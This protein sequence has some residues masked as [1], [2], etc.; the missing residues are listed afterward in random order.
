MA[1][2][3]RPWTTRNLAKWL[4]GVRVGRRQD[5][6]GCDIAHRTGFGRWGIGRLESIDRWGGRIENLMGGSIRTRS[7]DTKSAGGAQSRRWMNGTGRQM[8]KRGRVD[9]RHPDACLVDFEQLR[10]ERVE[11][12]VSFGKVIEGQLLPVPGRC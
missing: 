5:A 12:D 9:G 6:R 11:V 3:G 7:I 10:H 8:G 1:V 2:D 4:D